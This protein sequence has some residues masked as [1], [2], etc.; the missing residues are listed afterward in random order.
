[1]KAKYL[2]YILVVLMLTLAFA[3]LCGC[4]DMD[5]IMVD[6]GLTDEVD[7][8]NN[9]VTV[10]I[11]DIDGISLRDGTDPVQEVKRG[12]QFRLQFRVDPGYVYVSNSV[13]GEVV[14]N[15]DTGYYVLTVRT[16][17]AAMTIDLLVVDRDE[18]YEITLEKTLP[19][20]KVNF[21][22]GSSSVMLEPETC[23]VTAEYPDG[24]I[25]NGWSLG[26]ALTDGGTLISTDTTLKYTPADET[27][28]TTLYA[29]FSSANYYQ[30]VYHANGGTI[31][32]LDTNTSLE[33]Y[34]ITGKYNSTFPLQNTY[35]ENSD[36]FAFIRSGYIPIGFSEIPVDNFVAYNCKSEYGEVCD[37]CPCV[38]HIPGFVNMGGL[39]YV[40]PSS[41]ILNLNVV[42]AKVS[43]ESDFET[44][45]ER[46]TALTFGGNTAVTGARITKYKGNDSV[47]VIPEAIDGEK[48]ISIGES[49]FQK[50]SIK[51]VIINKNVLEIQKGA[52]TSSPNIDQIVYFD[53]LQYVWNN[54]FNE[55]NRASTIVLNAQRLPAYN[56][57]EGAFAIK[58]A[59]LRALTAQGKKKLVIVSGSSTLN[60]LKSSYME[61]LLNNEYSVINYGTNAMNPSVFFL[62]V[63]SN[64]V[65][66]GDII[67]HAPEWN[68][69]GPLGNNKIVWKLFRA[70]TQ[71]FDIFRE[72]DMSEYTN[73]WDAWRNFQVDN[74]EGKYAAQIKP[75]KE[76][77]Q[78]SG[79]GMN[80]YGD[81]TNS[82]RQTRTFNTTSRMNFGSTQ[83]NL[84]RQGAVNLNKINKKILAKGGTLLASFATA[85]MITY[86]NGDANWRSK[87]DSITNLFAEVLDYPVISNFGTYVME[88]HLMADS[89]WH[90]NWSGAMVRTREL[91]YDL[92]RYFNFIQDN[93]DAKN[94]DTYLGFNYREQLRAKSYPS[95]E[96]YP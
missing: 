17:S 54:S 23:T 31:V 80:L 12:T 49:A 59:R 29:N 94:S 16:V 84:V 67:I 44:S 15:A 79:I 25:F 73:Y 36:E 33:H 66:E 83:E 75:G 69:E 63:I 4:I 89:Q 95:W 61:S 2:K 50:F 93:P 68:S 32:K 11:R 64:Y 6:L 5:E 38:N 78:V 46:V 70:S 9:R 87:C 82:S 91:W 90:C 7:N 65:T 74:S 40:S 34:T 72:V 77:Y 41:G 14:Y 24:Y 52:F 28:K 10:V 13:G 57:G 71:C 62:D 21:A 39:C 43:P 76:G 26:A 1:M 48:V 86:N 85:D 19:G 58:Y 3:T 22:K 60:G 56:T 37:E 20:A 96:S 27:Y 30:M 8:M 81:L 55:T 45:T 35:N 53:S 88:G 42:W 47:I 18:V 92:D 51:T